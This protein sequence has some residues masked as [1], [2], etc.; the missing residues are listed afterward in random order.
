MGAGMTAG[1]LA[2]VLKFWFPLGK[3][4]GEDTMRLWFACTPAT[5]QLIKETFEGDLLAMSSVPESLDAESALAT[6]IL[7]DQ[8]PRCIYRNTASMFAYD[9]MAL[10]LARQAVSAGLDRDAALAESYGPA[11]RIFF[12]LPLEHSEAL[13]DQQQALALFRSLADEA[14]TDITSI[15]LKYAEEHAAIIRQF[16]RFP[17]RNRILGRESTAAEVAFLAGGGATFGVKP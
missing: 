1:N 5:D 8:F 12:Y 7:L 16:G 17:H 15:A 6:I 10:Q 14:K 11:L 4:I 9:S 2:K 3:T 13:A